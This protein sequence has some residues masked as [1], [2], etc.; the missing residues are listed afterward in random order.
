VEQSEAK[1]GSQARVNLQTKQ[2][3]QMNQRQK[4]SSGQVPF[5]IKVICF[6]GLKMVFLSEPGWKKVG[7]EGCT[8]S[9]ESLTAASQRSG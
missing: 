8:L 5:V 9:D 4:E 2:E 7:L 6:G 1:L 3:G